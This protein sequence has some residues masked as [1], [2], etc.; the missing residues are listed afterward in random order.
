MT[1]ARGGFGVLRAHPDALRLAAA[2]VLARLPMSMFS[3]A[4]I[5]LLRHHLHSYA[6]AGAAVA[7]Y[8]LA[9]A[10]TSPLLGRLAGRRGARA[11]L[12]PVGALRA[13]LFVA[14]VA[15]AQTGNAPAVIAI[16]A[17]AGA[18]EA[19]VT[20]VTRTAFARLPDDARAAALSLDSV[21]IELVFISG[22]L[23]VG[24][25]LAVAT[26]GY[27][28]IAAGG[29]GLIGNLLMTDVETV[30]TDGPHERG[31]IRLPA[32][33]S[34][35][36]VS[37][38]QVV[39]FAAIET[40]CTAAA[41]DAH[42]APLVGPLAAVWAMG[43]A[44]GGIVYGSRRWAGSPGRR[45]IAMAMAVGVGV[46]PLCTTRSPFVLLALLPIAGLFIA[47][48][49][50]ASSDLIAAAV[51]PARQTEAFAWVSGTATALGAAVGFALGG[52]VVQELGVRPT[53]AVAAAVALSAALWPFAE[54]RRLP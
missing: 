37:L 23:F 41:N 10:V 24:G 11:V 12:V 3:V 29:F 31:V 39:A 28:V 18:A 22:P 36:V 43:S 54:R 50:S 2:S 52:A 27:A 34:V 6:T 33:R 47:P 19:P 49:N 42:H 25:V 14:L 7:L 20:A 5:L 16:A 9:A 13:A 53:L 35:A 38:A 26:S 17:L 46:V 45:Y 21:L 8:G 44:L 1:E 4:S 40:A 32:V 15:V 51:P 48:S 30:A